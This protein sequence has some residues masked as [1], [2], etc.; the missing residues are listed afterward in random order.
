MS[1]DQVN[2]VL[3]HINQIKTLLSGGGILSTNKSDKWNFEVEKHFL[4]LF[5]EISSNFFIQ[6]NKEQQFLLVVHSSQS[7]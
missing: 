4:L 3:Y 5:V 6:R 7:C 2:E 1:R